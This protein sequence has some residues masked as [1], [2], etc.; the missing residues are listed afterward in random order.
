MVKIF[1]AQAAKKAQQK[2]LGTVK[3]SIEGIDYQGRGVAREKGKVYF[4]Q[5]ALP[6]ETVVAKV[7]NQKSS[8]AEAKMTKLIEASPNR[9]KPQCQYFEQCGGC[10]LQHLTHLSQLTA[11]QEMVTGLL[12]KA[13][14]QG[15]LNWQDPIHAE[16]FHYRHRARLAA[17]YD[18][19]KNTLLIGFRQNNS[20]RL[21]DIDSCSVIAK[22]L[23]TGLSELT[24]TVKQLEGKAHIS[25]ID[26]NQISKQPVVAIRAMADLSKRDKQVLTELAKENSWA[27]AINDGNNY[28]W[29]SAEPEL[30]YQVDEVT[31][32]FALDDFTQVNP[33]I[34]GKLVAKSLEWL[35]ISKDDTV[36][37]LFSGLGN[38]TLPMAKRAKSVTGI[39]G[40]QAMVSKA[41]AN[42]ELNLLSN[43]AFL[44]A[45]LFNEIDL[46]ILKSANVIVLD[47]ARAGAEAV[48][49]TAKHWQAS[50]VLYV[51][52][53][54]NS[55]ARDGK[56]LLEAGYQVKKVCV[57]DMFP[58]TSHIE[59]LALFERSN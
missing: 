20:K 18:K 33:S 51:S 10:Q 7:V 52:C 19:Q 34:N 38:F 55:L 36:V 3:L 13:G 15:S 42:A 47:P 41:K 39:E 24:S 25:H 54:P 8:L 44:H 35:A 58:H 5:G 31:I 53:N 11:K 49:Q 32:D 21:V 4:V 2:K 46:S 37:D 59:T 30:N 6:D 9:V 57:L 17:F 45:D 50:R 29:L 26:L 48:C 28:L 1:K 23:F 22:S 16:P 56:L 40:S 12:H 14:W 27:L 43:A